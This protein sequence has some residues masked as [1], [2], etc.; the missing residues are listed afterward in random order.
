MGLGLSR[1]PNGLE[2]SGAPRSNQSKT[3]FPRPVPG[4]ANH[5]RSTSAPARGCVKTPKSPIAFPLQARIARLQ[6]TLAPLPGQSAQALRDRSPPAR[7]FT[8]SGEV[9]GGGCSHFATRV[10]TGYQYGSLLLLRCIWTT[11]SY[12]KPNSVSRKVSRNRVSVCTIPLSSPPV[13]A[14]LRDSSSKWVR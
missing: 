6:C 2:L 3:R 12:L 1:Q 8:Q 7:L 5:A 4:N 10:D 9:L 14:L 13:A 11:S